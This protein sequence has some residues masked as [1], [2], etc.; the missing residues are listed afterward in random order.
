MLTGDLLTFPD[1]C[2][3]LVSRLV[4]CAFDPQGTFPFRDNFEVHYR[5]RGQ[6]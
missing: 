4:A 6:R 1:A 5:A 3:L 2:A